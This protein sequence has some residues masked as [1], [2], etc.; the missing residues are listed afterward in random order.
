MELRRNIKESPFHVAICLTHT[1]EFIGTQFFDL[2]MGL[3]TSSSLSMYRSNLLPIE[4]NRTMLVDE[5]LKDPST[6]HLLFIDTDIIPSRKDFVDYMISYDV[7]IIG[8]LCTK[9]VPPYEPIMFK[10]EAPKEEKLG[11]FWI[12][13]KKGL[14]EVDSTGTGCLLVKREVFEKMPRPYFV[15]TNSYTQGLYQSEDIYFLANAKKL[16]YPIYVD[17]SVTCVHMGVKGYG[18]EDF[19]KGL[20]ENKSII[21]DK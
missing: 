20:A 7:P 11:D 6:T 4:R 21:E 12:G 17:T 18:V 5:A 15:F 1:F 2:M 19:E 9:K 14:T 13:Y 3:K 10:W 16:G 8:L